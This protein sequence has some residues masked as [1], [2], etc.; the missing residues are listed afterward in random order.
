[1]KTMFLFLAVCSLFSSCDF[2]GKNELK[3]MKSVVLEN[4]ILSYGKLIRIDS[5]PSKYITPRP[6]DVW[7]PENYSSEKRYAVL[8]MHDGQMLFDSTTT[9]NKQEWMIDEVATSLM[10]QKITKDFIVVGVHNISEIRWQD[11]FPEKAVNFL[12]EEDKKTLKNISGKPN[13]IEQLFGDEYLKFIVSELKPY[14]DATYAV[15]DD[16]ENTFI[17]GSSMGGLMS[18]YA[19]SEYPDIFQ[20]AA[21]LSTHWVGAAP[22]EN[23]PYPNAIFKYMEANI[24]K[25]ENH[26]I[27]FDHGD[28]TLDQYYPKYGSKV[29]AIFTKKGYAVANYRNLFFP[30]ANHSEKSW[31][32]RIHIPLTFLLKK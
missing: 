3:T 1:M 9:W 23:N 19:I 11:L 10:A 13:D 30:G 4:A 8:Y 31:Q 29:D 15:F 12:S 28:K 2:V 20:G 18:M 16:K 26:K 7:L 32:S 25:S 24:P 17:V 21:C 6:V 27:Y 5:F 22:K 14:I